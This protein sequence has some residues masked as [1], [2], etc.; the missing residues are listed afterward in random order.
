MIGAIIWFV[1]LLIMGIQANNVGLALGFWLFTVVFVWLSTGSSRSTRNHFRQQ[2]EY[3]NAYRNYVKERKESKK[4][5][6][7]FEEKIKR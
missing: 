4:G 7:E 6:I 5:T 3:D 1:L 2:D